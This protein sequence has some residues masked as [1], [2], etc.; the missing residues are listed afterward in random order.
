MARTVQT[1]PYF[2]FF[3][4][5]FMVSTGEMDDAT[6]GKYIRYL[7]HQWEKGSIPHDPQLIQTIRFDAQIWLLLESKFPIGADNRRRN[8]RMERIRA[9]REAYI[10]K[11]S[12]AG[13]A[14][15]KA[16]WE[17]SKRIATANPIAN[18]K[19]D[20]KQ[21]GKTIA[22][23]PLPSSS[24]I[25][26]ANQSKKREKAVTDVP[27]LYIEFA[28]AFLGYQK[29]EY[30]KL[31]AWKNFEKRVIDGGKALHLFHTQ[32]GWT[33][34][35]IS[36]LLDWILVDDFWSKQIRTLGGIRKPGENGNMKFENAKASMGKRLKSAIELAQEMENELA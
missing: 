14:G 28:Q 4:R 25:P 26:L 15:A 33:E 8:P 24:P 5:D 22:S 19:G 30:P 10:A 36:Q 29:I 23:T 13:K 9:E 11:R 16:R 31:S 32:N 35:D 12:E 7:I 18:S 20:G 27:A 34:E 1:D 6:V 21:H 17:D 3:Y 2:P